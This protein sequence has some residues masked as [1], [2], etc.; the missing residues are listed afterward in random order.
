MW[1]K[2]FRWKFCLQIIS[3]TYP[4]GKLCKPWVIGHFTKSECKSNGYLD[5]QEQI[6][7][8]CSYLQIMSISC[9][10][11]KA[12]FFFFLPFFLVHQRFEIQEVPFIITDRY[13]HLQ[14]DE[15]RWKFWIYLFQ[16]T[17]APQ[18]RLVK[19]IWKKFRPVFR[20]MTFGSKDRVGTFLPATRC[21][22]HMTL[23]LSYIRKCTKT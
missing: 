19:R 20:P 16:P 12:I 1:W 14:T 11:L 8:P 13:M 6:L 22:G 4:K 15:K 21:E 17:Q 5:I 23:Q 2:H 10:V 9:F 7:R 3:E 18:S